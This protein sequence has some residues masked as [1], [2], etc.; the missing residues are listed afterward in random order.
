MV[1][2]L[3][4]QQIR[5]F[6]HWLQSCHA[7]G[8]D[9][10]TIDLDIFDNDVMA[11]LLDEEPNDRMVKTHGSSIRD[12]GMQLPTFNENQPAYAVWHAMCS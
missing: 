6:H 4:K 1:P 10:K 8:K 11:I 2:L 9:L 7:E 3:V 12:S 5:V